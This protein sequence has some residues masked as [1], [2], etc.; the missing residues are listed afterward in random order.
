LAACGGCFIATA[1]HGSL[2]K[3]VL[4]YVLL[5]LALIGLGIYGIKKIVKRQ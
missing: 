4:F 1:S 3:H 2:I 5:N